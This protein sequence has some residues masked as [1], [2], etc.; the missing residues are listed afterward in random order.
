MQHQL[1]CCECPKEIG[2]SSIRCSDQHTNYKPNKAQ[3]GRTMGSDVCV[4]VLGQGG[5]SSW[6]SLFH[7]R[8]PLLPG[9]ATCAASESGEQCGKWVFQVQ[10]SVWDRSHGGRELPLQLSAPSV[11]HE[12]AHELLLVG[13]HPFW[14]SKHPQGALIEEY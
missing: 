3:A 9:R 1:Q 6:G 7:P 12:G 14:I 13:S 4:S 11:S 10:R 8:G 2:L 5:I